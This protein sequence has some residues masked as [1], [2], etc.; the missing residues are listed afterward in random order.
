MSVIVIDYGMSNLGSIA[1][2]LEECGA[3]ILVS[4]NPNDLKTADKIILPGVGAFADGIKNLNERGWTKVIQKKVIGN[5][6]PILGICLGMQLLASKGY[7]GGEFK[8]LNLIEGEVIKFIPTN[9]ERI[10]HVGWNEIVKTKESILFNNIENGVDFY[11]VHSYHLKV[12]NEEDVI[13]KTKYC[14]EFVAAVN[15]ENIFGT[16]FHPE[17]S[18]PLGFEILKNF[19]SL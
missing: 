19:L 4:A 2:A 14:T 18:I 15:K 7:E 9:N 5:K 1:R 17:K 11:F 10:P 12:K 3:N 6:I 13:A 16:Q 8:G